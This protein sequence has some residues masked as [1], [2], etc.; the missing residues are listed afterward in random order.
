MLSIGTMCAVLAV[1]AQTRIANE[2][3]AA[4]THSN[5]RPSHS[6]H[7]FS[8]LPAA[9]MCANFWVVALAEPRSE[10]IKC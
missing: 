3:E 10:L 2:T 7:S 1:L 5:R 9:F 4:A 8:R 6:W